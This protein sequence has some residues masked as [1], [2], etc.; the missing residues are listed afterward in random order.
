MG[1]RPLL[2][3]LWD[4][5][6]EAENGPE[7]RGKGLWKYGRKCQEWFFAS[8]KEKV[9]QFWKGGRSP[10]NLYMK[11]EYIKTNVNIQ[12]DDCDYLFILRRLQAPHKIPSLRIFI[13]DTIIY[14]KKWIFRGFFYSKLRPNFNWDPTQTQFKPNPHPTPSPDIQT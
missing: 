7:G 9:L 14:S 13:P 4:L 3:Q 8:Q 2:V 10:K 6:W 11:T 1:S 5:C 12:I